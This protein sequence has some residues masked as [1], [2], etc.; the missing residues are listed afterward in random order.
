M[1]ACPLSN[2]QLIELFQD[3]RTPENNQDLDYKFFAVRAILTAAI[4]GEAAGCVYFP[5]EEGDF[6]E[7]I[8]LW[9]Q[10]RTN[11][12]TRINRYEKSDYIKGSAIPDELGAIELQ[13]KL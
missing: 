11:F 9:I 8:E 1:E 13:I 5:Q 10:R 7:S 6:A 4:E 3:M 12:T 2:S